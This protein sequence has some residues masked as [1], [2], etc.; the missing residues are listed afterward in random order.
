M[1]P[2]YVER[3]NSDL[4]LVIAAAQDAIVMV[5]SF[6]NEVS[7]DLVLKAFAK[8][9]EVI[10]GIIAD[11]SAM[12]KDIGKE[13]FAFEPIFQMQNSSKTW[14]KYRQTRQTGSMKRCLEIVCKRTSIDVAKQR[15]FLMMKRV[16]WAEN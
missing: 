8:A 13:K 10:N 5:E 1:N 12:V 6:S 4:D 16:I 9:Q 11:I 14:Q 2:T 3:K 15:R 7:E